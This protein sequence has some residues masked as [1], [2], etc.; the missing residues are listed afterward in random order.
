MRYAALGS[1]LLLVCF[2]LSGC[3]PYVVGTTARPVPAGELATSG[4]VYTIP[5]G[6]QLSDDESAEA[7][8]FSG[9]GVRARYGINEVSDFGIRIPSMSGLIINY[10]RLLTPGSQR[11]QLALAGMFGTGFVNF[12]EH[13]FLGTTLIASGPLTPDF[14]PYGGLRAMYVVP[15]SEAA[16]SDAPTLGGFLG[17]RIGRANLGISPEVGVYYDPSALDIRESNVIVVLAITIHGE[18]L[19]PPF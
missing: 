14:T 4:M 7:H 2:V 18:G 13:L 17:L 9:L 11:D 10:K 5:N 15:L 6:V 12:G 8:S 1:G 19:F 16:V 3:L